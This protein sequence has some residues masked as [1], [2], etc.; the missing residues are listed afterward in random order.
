MIA[1][2]TNALIRMLVEDDPD[3]AKLINDLVIQ[4]E[5]NS[6]QILILSE[7]LIETVGT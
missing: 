2:G 4:V 3:Q 6:G 1:F 7:V 5:T